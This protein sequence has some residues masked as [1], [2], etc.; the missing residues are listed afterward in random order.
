[1]RRGYPPVVTG[2]GFEGR[3]LFAK[4]CEG[5]TGSTC[6]RAYG[7]A[8]ARV[9]PR[10]A[11]AEVG[12]R[13]DIARWARVVRPQAVRLGSEA[14]CDSQFKIV[15]RGNHTVEPRVGIRPPRLRPAQAGAQLPHPE[16][17]QPAH[18]IVEPMIFEMKPLTDAERPGE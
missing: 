10:H 16:L 13:V 17:F 12:E 11:R 7:A 3:A 9:S 6:V 5:T 15:E 2:V 14:E 18:G 1:M 8:S 4:I